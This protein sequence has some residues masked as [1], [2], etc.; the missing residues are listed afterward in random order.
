MVFLLEQISEMYKPEQDWLF[1]KLLWKLESCNHLVLIAD[2]GWG[3]QDYIS[4]LRFQLAEKN[5]D[6]QI[7]MV[8]IQ[9][10]FSSD[11]FLKSLASAL[12]LQFPEEISRLDVE[13]SDL[14]ILSLPGQI[15]RK[16]KIKI[17]VFFANAH[18]FK[19]FSDY[20]T[21]LRALSTKLR[22]QRNCVF[23]FFKKKIPVP[24][25]FYSHPPPN[26]PWMNQRRMRMAFY[27]VFNTLHIKGIVSMKQR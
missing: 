14:S 7:C 10:A 9:S 23:C 5:P 26:C 22:N 18:L 16:H 8:D 20:R 27:K 6:L 1:E 19:R 15:A 3:I 21:F 24:D 2:Q 17:A 12:N 11:S 13:K 4:E 25:T